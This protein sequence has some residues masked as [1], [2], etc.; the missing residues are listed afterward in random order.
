MQAGRGPVGVVRLV[1]VNDYDD[2]G[3]ARSRH[4]HALGGDES[5]LESLPILVDLVVDDVEADR[6][7]GLVSTKS[8]DARRVGPVGVVRARRCRVAPDTGDVGHLELFAQGTFPFYHQIGCCCGAFGYHQ[9]RIILEANDD[10]VP[11]LDVYSDR[12]GGGNTV[13]GSSGGSGIQLHW[14]VVHIVRVNGECGGAHPG[15]AR[16]DR[17]IN[18]AARPVL[19]LSVLSSVAKIALNAGNTNVHQVCSAGSMRGIHDGK[20]YFHLL[21]KS[22]CIG[23]FGV[24][25]QSFTCAVVVMDYRGRVGNARFPGP[26]QPVPATVPVEQQCFHKGQHVVGENK[27]IVTKKARNPLTLTGFKCCTLTW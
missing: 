22:G 16:I 8:D 1:G 27:S 9:I 26:V 19:C 18:G 20:L 23:V 2:T 10:A 25:L 13:G 21:A 11:N 14:C 4:Q 17:A 15:L 7:L 6:G 12:R 3:T 5:H 24:Q